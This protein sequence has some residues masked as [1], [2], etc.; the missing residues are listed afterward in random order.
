MSKRAK[1]ND[2]AAGAGTQMKRRLYGIVL[3]FVLAAFLNPAFGQLPDAEQAEGQKRGRQWAVLI[4]IE[5]YHRAPRLRYTLNDV[6]Q[7]AKTLQQHGGVKK[8]DILSLTEAATNPRFQP[9]RTSLMTELPD[10][11]A[12][13]GPED[14]L[15]VYFSGHGFQDD[16]GKLYLAPIDCDP[17]NAA[18]TGVPV[19]WVRE[20]I[21][22]CKAKL[23]LLI[24]DACHAGSEKGDDDGTGVPAGDLAEPFRDLTGVVTLASSKANEKSQLW[25]DKEHSLFT[26]WLIQAIKGHA[27]AGR[28]GGDSQIQFSELYNYVHANVTN[29][30]KLHFP[31]KQTPVRVIR[32]GIDGDPVVVQLRPQ[33]LDEVLNNIAEQLALA[34]EASEHARLGVPEFS[35]NVGRDE[36][37]GIKFGSLR[38]HCAKQL[39]DQLLYL[40]TGKFSVIDQ[41]RLQEA[42]S[43]RNFSLD[44]L[45]RGTSLKAL[46]RNTGGMPVIALG[47]L[48]NRRGSLINL[49]CQLTTT[50]GGELMVR[51]GGTARLSVSEWGMLGLSAVV[52]A[53]DREGEPPEY[54]RKP[55]GRTEAD[56]VIDRLDTRAEGGHPLQMQGFP[57]PVSLRVD[58]EIRKPVAKGNEMFVPV[59]KGET[60]HIMV[61]NHYDGVVMMRL[62]VDGLN[63]LPQEVSLKGFD[64]AKSS[65]LQ[66]FEQT[67]PW[68]A[69]QANR[70]SFFEKQS[71][72]RKGI[73]LFE[74]AP[75]VNLAEAR[76]W[77]LDPADRR[78]WSVKGFV[79]ETGVSGK[80]KEFTVVSAEKSLAASKN[81]TEQI[82]LITFAFYVPAAGTARGGLG[83]T[84]GRELNENLKERSGFEVGHE[85]AIFHLRLVDAGALQT[86][87]R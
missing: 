18:A 11:L 74:V 35:A 45:H 34:M 76:P 59:R 57:F 64:A 44:D 6:V 77:V 42:L 2:N 9:L 87:I 83:T 55:Q 24:L 5:K 81:F 72:R 14:E 38:R 15:I 86:A 12:K 49:H 56:R 61:E 39:E 67:R 60:Y 78:R 32:S 54:G 41:R 33:P 66:F 22:G 85:L 27:D 30:A 75:R 46:S 52:K 4:G 1:H 63:T 31:R 7:L 29:T 28:N 82:G 20:Q 69:D 25:D 43:Q 21:A 71:K 50:D 53:D 36:L 47:T 16:E 68:A 40:G 23:K 48:S 17:Q 19:Q 62:L 8:G 65:P 58:G 80:L 26:Y 79:T 51:A 37:L 73:A 84:G 3:S 10:F 13:P 70:G